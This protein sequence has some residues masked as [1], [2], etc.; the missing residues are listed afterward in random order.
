MNPA[1]AGG[2]GGTE[3]SSRS[4]RMGNCGDE[5]AKPWLVTLVLVIGVF[6]FADAHIAAFQTGHHEAGHFRQRAS[7]SAA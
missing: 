4:P 3:P 5:K 1:A 6:M 7:R 2:G